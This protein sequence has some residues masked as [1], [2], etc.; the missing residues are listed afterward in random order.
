MM[1][2]VDNLAVSYGMIEAL[3][4]VSVQIDAGEIVTLIGSNGAGKTTL[5][6]TISGLLSAKSG[7]I[8]FQRSGNHEIA[9]A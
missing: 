4:G 1:L 2:S 3:H 6:R 7:S 9:R 8:Q 5:L